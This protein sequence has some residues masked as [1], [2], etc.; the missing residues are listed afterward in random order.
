MIETTR[1]VLRPLTVGDVD[2]FVALHAD[3]RVNRFVGSYTPETA[4][5]RLEQ[6]ERQWA[7]RGHGLFA[8]ELKETGEFLGRV[9]PQYWEQFDEVEL[10]WTLRAEAW[11][12]GYATEAAQAALDWAFATLPVDYLTA[13]IDP[14]NTASQRVAARLGFTPGGRDAILFG[15]QVIVHTLSRPE[16]S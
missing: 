14:A 15:R 8:A 16:P 11:G 3:P 9:G 2:R 12:R 5:A 13:M 10:A 4:L 7:E 1:L 6:V